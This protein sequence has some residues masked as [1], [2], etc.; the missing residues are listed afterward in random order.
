MDRLQRRLNPITGQMEWLVP[1]QDEELFYVDGQLVGLDGEGKGKGKPKG[2]A[3]HG[4]GKDK[5]NGKAAGNNDKGQDGKGKE[6]KGKYAN[7]KG[8]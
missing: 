3:N 1:L 6:G 4:K 8:I 7:G 2:K 5:N